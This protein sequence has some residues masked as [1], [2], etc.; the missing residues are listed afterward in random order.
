M[1]RPT[2]P[3]LALPSSRVVVKKAVLAAA[4][5]ALVVAP[6]AQAQARVLMPGV[7]YD[8]SVQ[9]T[10]RGPVVAHVLRGPRPVGL[11]ALKPILS[12][13]VIIGRE[14]VTQ[15]QRRLSTTATVAGVNGDLFN[16]SVGYPSGL[17]LMNGVLAP[18]PNPDRLDRGNGLARRRWFLLVIRS[19][20]PSRSCFR[21]LT[22]CGGLASGETRHRST[23]RASGLQAQLVPNEGSAEAVH[24]SE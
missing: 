6:S 15:M 22:A 18:P 4:L 7:T 24:H 2:R 3:G 10:P 9:F 20:S 14:K 1:A 23:P 13:D 16:L 12:N 8:R 11:Y 17:L 5:A 19:L 21:Y